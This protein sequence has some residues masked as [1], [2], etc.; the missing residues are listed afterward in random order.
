MT[1]PRS[2]ILVGRHPLMQDLDRA[3]DNLSDEDTRIARTGQALQHPAHGCHLER[4]SCLHTAVAGRYSV[5]AAVLT[6]STHSADDIN[7]THL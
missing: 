4:P 1:S 3:I 5:V 7:R 2:S 6:A